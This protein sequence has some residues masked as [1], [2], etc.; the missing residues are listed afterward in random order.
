MSKGGLLTKG[1]TPW[2]IHHCHSYNSS[3][4]LNFP[5]TCLPSCSPINAVGRSPWCVPVSGCCPRA[6]FRM[7]L[8]GLVSAEGCLKYTLPLSRVSY[9]QKGLCLPYI[10]RMSVFSVS[11][12]PTWW[13][14]AGIAQYLGA[15]GFR[16]QGRLAGSFVR[17]C[18]SP[19][20]GG[21]TVPHRMNVEIT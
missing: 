18:G 11:R 20:R 3:L 19:S 5:F 8:S 17:A 7:G 9:V 10:Q 13:D 14:M 21:A 4:S 16:V 12:E 6:R 15:Q 2:A 1:I